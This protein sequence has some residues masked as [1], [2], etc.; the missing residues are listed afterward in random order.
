MIKAFNCPEIKYLSSEEKDVLAFITPRFLNV[1]AK[2]LSRLTHTLYFE[3][4]KQGE[5]LNPLS[6]LSN[7]KKLRQ[8]I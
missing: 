4:K 7:F 8:T 1:S 5:R 3:R 6:F 2:T